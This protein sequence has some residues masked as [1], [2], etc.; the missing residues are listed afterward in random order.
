RALI[1]EPMLL[2]ADEPTGNLDP[3]MAKE[4]IALFQEVNSR[5]TTVLVATHDREMIQPK[6][7]GGLTLEPGRIVSGSAVLDGHGEH[8]MPAR[9]PKLQRRLLRR[10]R[11]DDEDGVAP[12]GLDELQVHRPRR[13]EVLALHGVEGAAALLQV[14]A[15]PAEDAQGGVGVDEELDVHEP[16][17]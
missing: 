12:R 6:C 14:A 7:N 10:A 5:G 3:E 11:R 15:Q 13:G 16:P 1:N 8:G 9:G 2:L 4:I 17:Q